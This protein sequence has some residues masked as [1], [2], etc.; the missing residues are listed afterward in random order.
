[1]RIADTVSFLQ[2]A[3]ETG[4]WIVGFGQL[5]TDKALTQV[6]R[7]LRHP[8]VKILF[9]SLPR[10]HGFRR[11]VSLHKPPGRGA[12]GKS[13]QLLQ[14]GGC[15]K[16]HAPRLD[17]QPALQFLGQSVPQC[18]EPQHGVLKTRW[19]L[20]SRCANGPPHEIAHLAVHRR[21]QWKHQRN[22]PYQESLDRRPDI[23]PGQLQR[24]LVAIL[25][26]GAEGLA[27]QPLASKV[28]G[29]RRLRK[30]AMRKP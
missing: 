24:V 4:A 27:P 11:G 15:T 17:F 19:M 3:A 22:A 8:A 2:P 30:S 9:E 25:G 28:R 26:Q 23:Q 16:G 29:R 5:A 10:P 7:V 20:H 14:V 13:R 18:V 6:A 12:L 1:M 21:R